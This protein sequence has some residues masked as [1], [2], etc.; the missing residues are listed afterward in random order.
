MTESP[1]FVE[2]HIWDI[3]HAG[4]RC[5]AFCFEAMSNESIKT[6]RSL[7][8][9]LSIQNWKTRRLT[10]I[11]KVL[12]FHAICRMADEQQSSVEQKVEVLSVWFSVLV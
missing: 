3:F 4:F 8:E 10:P 2:L 11:P 5:D 9:P 7:A 1:H 12:C 6:L